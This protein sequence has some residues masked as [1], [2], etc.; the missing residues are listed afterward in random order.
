MANDRGIASVTGH[1]LASGTS[2]IDGLL[3]GRRARGQFSERPQQ[4]LLAWG[5]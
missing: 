1:G 5:D 2:K 4:N 3:G